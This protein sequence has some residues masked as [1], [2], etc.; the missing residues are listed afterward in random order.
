MISYTQ[1]G[2]VQLHKKDHKVFAPG[3]IE[4]TEPWDDG[5]HQTGSVDDRLKVM[6]SVYGR[7]GRRLYVNRYDEETGEVVRLYPPRLLRRNLAEEALKLT[8]D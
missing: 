5:I 4:F 2:R 6:I 1:N 3:E 8:N 7:P